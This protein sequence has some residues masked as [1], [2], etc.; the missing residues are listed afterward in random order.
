MGCGL[1]IVQKH[2]PDDWNLFD[3]LSLLLESLQA[4]TGADVAAS[5][6]NTGHAVLGADWI[7]EYATGSIETSVAFSTSLVRVAVDLYRH[8]YQRQ[9]RRLAA[10]GH[11]RRQHAGRMKQPSVSDFREQLGQRTL[12][13]FRS[14][15]RSVVL[16]VLVDLF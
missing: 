11:Y 7:L 6:N 9:R 14:G 15:H 16:D 3:S 10:A 5:T 12:D 2:Y 4:R 13:D 8:Q 1:Q